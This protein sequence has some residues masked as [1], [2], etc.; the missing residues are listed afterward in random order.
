MPGLFTLTTHSCP[1]LGWWCSCFLWLFTF[2]CNSLPGWCGCYFGIL[3]TFG[4]MRFR[5]SNFLVVILTEYTDLFIQVP[6]S[7]L[8][9]PSC[10][11]V[12]RL[13]VG[14]DCFK[15]VKLFSG[16]VQVVRKKHSHRSQSLPHCHYQI[17][18]KCFPSVA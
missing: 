1:L 8:I 10:R 13:P 15:K 6:P 16:E 17:N 4:C 2:G 14:G 11:T 12:G 5:A 9:H 18:P 7:S 3:F